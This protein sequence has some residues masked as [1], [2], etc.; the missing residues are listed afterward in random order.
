VSW[1]SYTW[2]WVTDHATVLATVISALATIA[3]ALFT[4]TLA[5]ATTGLKT[6]AD[7]QIAEAK[8]LREI[9]GQQTAIQ[10]LQA[11]ITVKQHGV[12]LQ[13]FFAEHRPR[14]V[15]KDVFFSAEGEFG[16]VTFELANIGGSE[17]RVTGGF[18]AIGFVTDQR[19]FKSMTEGSLDSVDRARLEAGELR[20]FAR[21]VPHE[22]QYH[23]RFP[24]AARMRDPGNPKPLG[25]LY[26][27]GSLLYVDGRGEE[28]G[29]VRMSVF[30]REWHPEEG[31]FCRTNNPDHEYAD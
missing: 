6:S 16:T 10:G 12:G 3:I 13:Q 11:D 2:T 7:Q 25:K 5:R 9:A 27:F 22:V 17:A 24:N 14:V 23:M 15:L 1:I 21:D 26:F 31:A 29:T 30:R 19:Q 28:F 18:V 4:V 20:Q 8:A